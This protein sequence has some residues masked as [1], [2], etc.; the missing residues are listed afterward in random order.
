MRCE[1]PAEGIAFLPAVS[2]AAII[3]ISA[4]LSGVLT[5][6]FSAAA[7]RLKKHLARR[8]LYPAQHRDETKPT[9][10]PNSDKSLRQTA[11]AATRAA[12]SRAE[13]LSS[14]SRRS[15]AV[16]L[17][18]PGRS[19]CPGRGQTWKSVLL[20]GVSRHYV[21]PVFPVQ[22][23]DGKADRRADSFPGPYAGEYLDFIF[24]Y[25]H[26]APRPKPC[27]LRASSPFMYS[28]VM[29]SPA[30]IPS[31]MTVNCFPCDSPA[32]T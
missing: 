1:Y 14:I 27:C 21:S 26:A 8:R 10:T 3:S 2:I 22:V 6:D 7:K 11:P 31:S 30:G 18:A 13:A 25:F 20:A 17:S 4:F 29:E 32:V 16:N 12:V 23:L 15:L 9:L 24:L 19:A 28:L 5:G